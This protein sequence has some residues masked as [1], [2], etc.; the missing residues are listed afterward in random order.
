VEE[1]QKIRLKGR[2]PGVNG[3]PPGD[4]LL[5]CCIA[6][7][8]YFTRHGADIYVDVPVSVAEAAL[9][10]KIEVPAID[11]RVTV[12]LPPGTPSGAKLRLKGHGAK[13]GG[14]HERGDQY[15]VIQIV[16]PRPLTDEQRRF[17]EQLRAIDPSN[18]R[19][20]CPWEGGASR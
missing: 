6:P 10:A 14:S 20:H 15:A 18:P 4:L 19:T 13:K 5:R 2:V 7:H 11:G 16:P 17:F 3:G 1:G 9:G 12:T 8:P